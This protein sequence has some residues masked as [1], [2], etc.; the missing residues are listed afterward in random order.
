MQTLEEQDL[1]DSFEQ[2]EWISHFQTK[3]I[4]PDERFPKNLTRY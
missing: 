1:L 3:K 2:G 4:S